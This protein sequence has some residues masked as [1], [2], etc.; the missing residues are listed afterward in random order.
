MPHALVVNGH[1]QLAQ[2]VVI[3]PKALAAVALDQ[4]PQAAHQPGIGRLDS[5][6]APTC[7]RGVAAAGQAHERA[8]LT[9]VLPP[10][11]DVVGCFAPDRGSGYFFRKTS[12]IT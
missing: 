10:F 8:G 5:P 11:A 12:F 7:R 4:G 6:T 3:L 2:P 1:A 9:L